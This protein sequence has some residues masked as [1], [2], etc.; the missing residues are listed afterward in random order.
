MLALFRGSGW[1]GDGLFDEEVHEHIKL[2]EVVESLA[3]LFALLDIRLVSKKGQRG[4]VGELFDQPSE[5]ILWVCELSFK[6]VVIV[7][8]G[9]K[10]SDFLSDCAA[11]CGGRGVRA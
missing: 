2:C 10:P 5:S 7:K 3:L 11:L 9:A 8:R 6:L 1:Y 4:D